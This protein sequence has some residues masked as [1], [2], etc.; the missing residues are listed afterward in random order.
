[1]PHEP[2]SS[3]QGPVGVTSGCSENLTAGDLS[4]GHLPA[5]HLPEWDSY[6]SKGLCHF[7][8]GYVSALGTVNLHEEEPPALAGDTPAV[9]F[10]LSSQ[11]SCSAEVGV[12][13]PSPGHWSGKAGF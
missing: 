2:F 1:M 9:P 8:E 7:Y 5:S 6:L 11:P 4:G 12:S 10:L 13:L 3:K